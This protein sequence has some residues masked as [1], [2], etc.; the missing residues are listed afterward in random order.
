MPGVQSKPNKRLQVLVVDDEASVRALLSEVVR[1]AG[2]DVVS[3]AL[4]GT[5]AVVQ[6]EELRPDVVLMDIHMPQMNG[7]DAMHAILTA[8]TTRRVMLISGGYNL[9]TLP[10]NLTQLRDVAFLPK[11]F[12]V[13]ALV[14]LLTR[15]S[16]ELG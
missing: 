15:W 16:T 6:A 10:V 1:F 9:Q 3:T 4:N 7:I 14:D 2:Y 13:S 11:P 5:Q 8:G 12:D